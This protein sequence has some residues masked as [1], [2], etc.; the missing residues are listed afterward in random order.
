MIQSPLD[1]S[2]PP[3]ARRT[4]RE[5]SHAAARSMVE[6]A[7]QHQRRIVAALRTHGPMGR[8]AI[9]SK[10]GMDPI[11]VARRMGELVANRLVELTDDHEETPSGRRGSVW[12][13]VA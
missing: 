11:A 7:A 6:G 4:D 1:F 12:R 9:A 8:F 13:A 3:R 2:A 5:T 10:T